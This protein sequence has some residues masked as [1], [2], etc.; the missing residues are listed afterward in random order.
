MY[1]R[2]CKLSDLPVSGLSCLSLLFE[3]GYDL[4]TPSLI[5]QVLRYHIFP[6][7][8]VLKSLSQLYMERYWSAYLLFCQLSFDANCSSV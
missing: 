6:K 5:T 8:T 2:A 1:T 3:L 7:Y 4:F